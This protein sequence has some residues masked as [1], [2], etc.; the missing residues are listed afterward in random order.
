MHIANME[1]DS[2][3]VQKLGYSSLGVSLPKPWAESNGIQ[4]GSVV[5][6]SIEDDGTLRVRVGPF[7]E[8]P[9]A[10]E[11]TIDAD[12][13]SGPESLTRLIT[14]NY[15]VASTTIKERG[16][17]E[18]SPGHLQKITKPSRGLP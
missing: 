7:E 10:A 3:K 11:A 13:W 9:T 12:S 1:L 8:N 16:P 5:N 4:P 14:G 18:I 6:M 2:R 17:E 15:S